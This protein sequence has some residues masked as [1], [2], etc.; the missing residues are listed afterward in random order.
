MLNE[1]CDEL[2]VTFVTL[3][4]VNSFITVQVNVEVR[5]G[6]PF[7]DVVKVNKNIK[8]ALQLDT[9]W[10]CSVDTEDDGELPVEL[11]GYMNQN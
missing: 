6:I 3:S 2:C 4:E 9:E 8:A 11:S 7:Q 10:L 5:Q 1:H